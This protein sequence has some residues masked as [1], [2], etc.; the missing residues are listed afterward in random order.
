MRRAGCACVRV[1]GLDA[2]DHLSLCTPH[3]RRAAAARA[4]CVWCCMYCRRPVCLS[5]CLCVCVSACWWRVAMSRWHLA[6]YS[7][8]RGLSPHRPPAAWTSSR[9]SRCRV[10]CVLQTTLIYAQLNLMRATPAGHWCADAVVAVSNYC[11]TT[12][13][14]SLWQEASWRNLQTH[15]LFETDW[16]SSEWMN[17]WRHEPLISLQRLSWARNF[18]EALS[19]LATSQEYSYFAVEYFY[20]TALLLII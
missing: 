14:T 8:P 17:E 13:V 7:Q 9:Y 19:Q 3:P 18:L 16:F 15:S 11:C 20:I 6:T 1:C 12:S 5:V 4:A 2:T 10:N